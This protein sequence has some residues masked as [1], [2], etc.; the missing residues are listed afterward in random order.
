MPQK[1]EGWQNPHE[2]FFGP[3][4]NTMISSIKKSEA[5][6]GTQQ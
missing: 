4:E 5:M 6:A 2:F 3:H 1:S